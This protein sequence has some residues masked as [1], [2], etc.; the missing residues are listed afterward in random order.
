MKV[1]EVG[2]G[3]TQVKKSGTRVEVQPDLAER[4]VVCAAEAVPPISYPLGVPGYKSQE[5]SCILN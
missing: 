5:I 2:L 4:L 3:K 1:K